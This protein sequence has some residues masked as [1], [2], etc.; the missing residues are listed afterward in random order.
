MNN[1]DW[2]KIPKSAGVYCLYDLNG[3]PLYV[4]EASSSNDLR[5]RLREHFTQQTSTVVTH[6]RLDLLDVWHVKV[7]LTDQ[8]KEAENQLITRF[9]PPLNRDYQTPDSEPIDIDSPEVRLDLCD[10]EEREARLKPER[11]VPA[12]LHHIQRMFNVD[13]VALQSL[14]RGEQSRKTAAEGAIKYHLGVLQDA[15]NDFYEIPDM[16]DRN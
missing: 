10:E 4:G 9:K 11:R 12:K 5:G 14:S 1:I 6:G 8:N 16:I 3:S 2:R 7:W 15:L 13:R